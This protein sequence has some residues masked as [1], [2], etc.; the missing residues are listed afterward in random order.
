MFFSVPTIHGYLDGLLRIK[1]PESITFIGS[2]RFLT[3]LDPAYAP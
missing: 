2:T 1:L 3:L